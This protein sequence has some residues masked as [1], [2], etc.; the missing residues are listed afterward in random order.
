[1]TLGYWLIIFFGGGLLVVELIGVF[2]KAPNDTITEGWRHLDRKLK[3][4]PQWIYRVF[5]VGLLGWTILH[6]SGVWP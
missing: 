4:W 3:G 1:M 6:L 2:R 5:M